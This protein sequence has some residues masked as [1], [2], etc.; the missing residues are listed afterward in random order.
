MTDPMLI[1]KKLARI[2]SCVSDLQRLARPESI[3]TDLRE[4]RFV[5][6]TLQIAI[7]DA[8]DVASHVVSDRR[9]GEPR[10]NRELFDLLHRDGWIDRDLT[11]N[12]RNM[13]GFR[14][15]LVHGYDDVDLAVVRDVL[16][17][18]VTDL[19]AFVGAVRH[20]LDSTGPT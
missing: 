16:D 17:V 20:R 9:L 18:H 6:H 2:E 4:R 15:V 8:L 7:Q 12:L 5:E 11:V 1:A 3:E 14:N 19:S 10:T 13:A